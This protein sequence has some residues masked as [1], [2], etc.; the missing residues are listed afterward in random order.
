[1]EFRISEK[2]TYE[3][4]TKYLLGTKAK[5]QAKKKKKI[6]K[7]KQAEE[8]KL[9]ILQNICFVFISVYGQMYQDEETKQKIFL[10]KIELKMMTSRKGTNYM[11]WSNHWKKKTFLFISHYFF[12][13]FS[14]SIYCLNHFCHKHFPLVRSFESI[15]FL[16]NSF[17]FVF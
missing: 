3:T 17:F 8:K 11:R 6:F 10:I 2:K 14:F 4:K 13:F 5:I 7:W 1:M 9:Q 16:F 15:L 12:Y